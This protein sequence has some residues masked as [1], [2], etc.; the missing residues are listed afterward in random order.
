MTNRDV[1]ERIASI[2]V[3]GG[4]YN[5]IRRLIDDCVTAVV[6]SDNVGGVVSQTLPLT[7]TCVDDAGK[8]TFMAGNLMAMV[9]RNRENLGLEVK[10]KQE[11][12]NAKQ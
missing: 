11:D 10:F 1:A 12:G 6:N 3:N 7:R 5:E 4:T 2:A 9:R 8:A